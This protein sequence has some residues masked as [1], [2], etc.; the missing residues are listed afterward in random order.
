MLSGLVGDYEIQ[1]GS[2]ESGSKWTKCYGLKGFS[3]IA[4][5]FEYSDYDDFGASR[6]YGYKRPHLG[7]DMVGQIG[8]PVIAVESGYVEAAGASV[9]AVLTKRDIIITRIC[10]RT[11]RFR[12]I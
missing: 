1:D 8:T 12:W 7:H 9:S 10:A 11:I 5:G 6:S 2:G 4:K 3:P